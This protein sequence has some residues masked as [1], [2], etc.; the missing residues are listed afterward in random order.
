MTYILSAFETEARALIQSYGLQKD[1]NHPFKLFYSEEILIIISG[2]GQEKAKEAIEYLLLNFP[3]KTDD[4][5]INLGI[6]AGQKEFAVGTLL[7]IKQLQDEEESHHLI[8]CNEYIQAVSCFSSFVPLDI[9]TTTDIAEM[10]AMG[11]YRVIHTYFPRKQISFLKIVSD[12]FNPIKFSKAF[13]IGLF[14][15]KLSQIQ[16]HITLL[17]KGQKCQ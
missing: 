13:I 17:Q 3:N 1:V 4:I 2:M 11:I 9:P 8:T 16:D 12:N 14:Q 10:E 5:F 7:Q 6:C 15:N